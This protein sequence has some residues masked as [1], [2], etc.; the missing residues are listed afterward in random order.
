MTFTCCIILYSHPFGARGANQRSVWLDFLS[1]WLPVWNNEIN[2]NK[3]WLRGYSS[4][5]VIAH[6]LCYHILWIKDW[7]NQGL[8]PAALLM[9]TLTTN[10][11]CDNMRSSHH[12]FCSAFILFATECSLIKFSGINEGNKLVGFCGSLFHQSGNS[13]VEIVHQLFSAKKWY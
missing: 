10:T 5:F 2:H 8:W 7:F 9:C 3:C 11:N 12:I 1:D 6:W 4:C 13:T